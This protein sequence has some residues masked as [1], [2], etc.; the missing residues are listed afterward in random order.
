M[1]TRCIVSM[2]LLSRAIDRGDLRSAGISRFIAKPLRS[3]RSP[4]LASASSGRLLPRRSTILGGCSRERGCFAKNLWGDFPMLAW[5]LHCRRQARCCLRPRGVGRHSSISR[6]PY[7]LR[8]LSGDR[9]HPKILISR[10]YGSDSGR[11]PFTSLDSCTCRCC[12]GRYTTGRLTNPYPEGLVLAHSLS[13][14]NQ[15]QVQ[16]IINRHH[17]AFQRVR[18]FA[19]RSKSLVSK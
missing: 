8:L 3:Y 7:C 19:L 5:L 16:T 10:G 6:R 18:I 11:T 15:R 13:T 14:V 2:F 9:H 12:Q 17:A 1:L 4:S